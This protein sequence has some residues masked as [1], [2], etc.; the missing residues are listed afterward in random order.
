MTP[1]DREPNDA[2]QPAAEAESRRPYEPPQLEVHGSVD[3][4]TEEGDDSSNPVSSD[5]EQKTDFAL[6][7]ADDILERLARIPIQTWANTD[8]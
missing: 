2:Q 5:R 1:S 8:T 3:D 4:V 7:D 6:V